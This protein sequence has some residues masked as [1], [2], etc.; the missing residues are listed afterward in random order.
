VDASSDE[1]TRKTFESY[2]V[3]EEDLNEGDLRLLTVDNQLVLP[4]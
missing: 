1:L 4:S 2:M 3:L